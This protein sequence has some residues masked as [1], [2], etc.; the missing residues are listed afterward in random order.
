[1]TWAWG[2]LFGSFGF[3]AYS[4]RRQAAVPAARSCSFAYPIQSLPITQRAS[5]P[6]RFLQQYNIPAEIR[7]YDTSI[8]G[9]IPGPC[10]KHLLV[11]FIRMT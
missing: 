8:G 6:S 3:S 1:M 4:T 7:S 9:P 11:L 2:G 5:P 10:N